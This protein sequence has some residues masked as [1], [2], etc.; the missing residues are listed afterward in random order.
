MTDVR[1]RQC[2]E[3][4]RLDLA[5]VSVGLHVAG[6]RSEPG[7]LNL[8]REPKVMIVRALLLARDDHV[9]QR[10]RRLGS[11]WRRRADRSPRSWRQERSAA[12]TCIAQE[13]TSAQARMKGDVAGVAHR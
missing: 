3:L 2:G 6:G 10:Q 4:V 5:A 13:G 8:R 11:R 12:E 1:G 9:L 7:D